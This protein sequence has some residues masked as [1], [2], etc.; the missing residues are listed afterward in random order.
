[1]DNTSANNNAA[2]YYKGFDQNTLGAEVGSV[3]PSPKRSGDCI[4]D[5]TMREI[6]RRIIVQI[7]AS[8]SSSVNSLSYVR[9][10]EPPSDTSLIWQQISPDTGASVGSTQTYD[11][12]TGQWVSNSA[13]LDDIPP[14]YTA[15]QCRSGRVCLVAGTHTIPFSSDMNDANYTPIITP[16]SFD[17]TT[18]GPAS[19]F[20]FN[21]TNRTSSGFEI[22]LDADGCFFWKAEYCTST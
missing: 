5:N 10:V 17:G 7:D 8:L 13:S 22:T 11:D 12:T 14:Q 18:Y 4:D 6:A 2:G 16:T 15:P 19:Y 21:I 1:M 9:S 20:N 3:S